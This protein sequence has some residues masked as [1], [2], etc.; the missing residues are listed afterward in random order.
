MEELGN[1]LGEKMVEV[2]IGPQG[3]PNPHLLLIHYN[4][5]LYFGDKTVIYATPKP[6]DIIK[7]N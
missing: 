4:F 5:L 2:T 1:I 3:L 7:D 6:S